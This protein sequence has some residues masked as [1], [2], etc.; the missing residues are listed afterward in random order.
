[1]MFAPHRYRIGTFASVAQNAC[2]STICISKRYSHSFTNTHT[3][4]LKINSTKEVFT[5]KTVPPFVHMNKPCFT[6]LNFK[7]NVKPNPKN[8]K[9]KYKSNTIN[10]TPKLN[11]LSK[12]NHNSK[13][14]KFNH[15]SK[16]SNI[17]HCAPFPFWP[18][19][20]VLYKYSFVFVRYSYRLLPE[21][22]RRK[23][24]DFIIKHTKNHRFKLRALLALILFKSFAIPLTA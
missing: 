19:V 14:L 1:M 20:H 24:A 9:S 12:Y 8:H 5:Q 21:W 16:L 3:T 11:L 23:I 4:L 2:S 18:V 7:P 17:S 10:V 15:N 22:I 6:N 13:I